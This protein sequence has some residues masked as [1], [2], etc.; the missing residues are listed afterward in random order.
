MDR[1][2]KRKTGVAPWILVAA[3]ALLTVLFGLYGA[4]ACFV[5]CGRIG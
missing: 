2:E 1:K 3:V 5:M 4:F